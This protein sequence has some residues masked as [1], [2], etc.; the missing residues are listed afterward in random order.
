[1]S[2]TPLTDDHLS[3]VFSK[4]PTKTIE[5]KNSVGNA[6]DKCFNYSLLF[7][8]PSFRY[9]NMEEIERYLRDKIPHLL[10]PGAIIFESVFRLQHMKRRIQKKPIPGVAMC[11]WSGLEKSKSIKLTNKTLVLG[12]SAIEVGIDFN[13][14]SL[15]FEA[16]YWASAIQRLGR[17]GRQ[18]DGVA[19]MLTKKDIKP[20][21]NNISELERYEFENSV[22]RPAL[23]DR[24]QEI[25]EGTTFRGDNFNFILFDEELEK[26]FFYN[27]NIF[28]MFE[29]DNNYNQSWRTLSENEKYEELEKFGILKDSKEAQEIIVRDRLFPFW[30]IVKGHLRD[31]YKNIEL[32]YD[33]ERGELMI[34]PGPYMF[35]SSKGAGD[36][37]F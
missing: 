8:A 9:T 37:D 31:K 3:G 4:F 7:E 5:F 25:S 14:R 21:I 22:L 11:E 32:N 13:F 2:A 6:S 35:F 30:G 29:I 16:N 33:R 17:V 1:M 15:I 18:Q 24:T 36:G 34:E 28:K 19:I 20:F 26:H 10:L 27:E 12:T 23:T